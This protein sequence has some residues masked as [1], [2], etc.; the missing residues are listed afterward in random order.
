MNHTGL[1]LLLL[2]SIIVVTVGCK[3]TSYSGFM[4]N[5]KAIHVDRPIFDIKGVRLSDSTVQLS[6]MTSSSLRTSDRSIRYVDIYIGPDADHLDDSIMVNPTMAGT[7]GTDETIIFIGEGLWDTQAA[8]ASRS[9]VAEV[10]VVTATD[11][12][13][14][15]T[16]IE[17]QKAEPLDVKPFATAVG[18]ASGAESTIEVGLMAKR[19]YVPQG[20]YLPTS[21]SFRVLISDG[22]GSVVWRSDAGLA[23]LSVVTLVEPQNANAIHRYVMPWDGRDLG[24]QMVPDGE[25]HADLIIPS[26]PKPYTASISFKWPPR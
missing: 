21:E 12:L 4:R 6:F 18:G 25:Y 10:S 13:I 9:A 1:F 2:T 11:H 14:F 20:E 22:K 19:I 16:N 7:P 3:S 17:Y 5:N 15:R 23:F 8:R 24:G 26:R